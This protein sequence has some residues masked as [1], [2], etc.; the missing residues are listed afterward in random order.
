MTR[1]RLIVGNPEDDDI[2]I[3]G[4]LDQNLYEIMDYEETDKVIT[5][6]KESWSPDCANWREVVVEVRT[7]LLRETFHSPVLKAKIV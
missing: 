4:A 5:K 7:D 6:M 1:I 2:L 3:A